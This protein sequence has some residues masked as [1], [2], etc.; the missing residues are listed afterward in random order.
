[1]MPRMGCKSKSKMLGNASLLSILP[2]TSSIE[3]ADKN[4]PTIDRSE[5]A[6]HWTFLFMLFLPTFHG[7]FSSTATA[8]EWYTQEQLDEAVMAERLK[9]DP[10]GDGRVGLPN[11][12][13]FL[14]ILTGQRVVVPKEH[15]RVAARKN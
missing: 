8:T 4:F 1:M 12:I 7:P 11:V 14:Q 3:N 10:D 13:Y 9:Y 2:A 15:P 6:Y 5:V